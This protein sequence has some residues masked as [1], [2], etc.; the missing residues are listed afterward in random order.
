MSK[1]SKKQENPKINKL[2]LL[3]FIEPIFEIIVQDIISSRIKNNNEKDNLLIRY[4]ISNNKVIDL[5]NYGGDND[6][7]IKYKYYI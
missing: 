2:K 7:V 3:Q 6:Q 4:N 1:L 5:T